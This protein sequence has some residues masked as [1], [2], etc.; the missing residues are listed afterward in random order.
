MSHSQTVRLKSC[1]MEV[2]YTYDDDT[3]EIESITPIEGDTV[4]DILDQGITIEDIQNHL[5]ENHVELD[6]FEE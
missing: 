4:L 3:V 5:I 1:T 2:E 6:R